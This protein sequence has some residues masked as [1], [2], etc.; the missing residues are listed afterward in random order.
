M[1]KFIVR[2]IQYKLLVFTCNKKFRGRALVLACIFPL[3]F[4]LNYDLI[5][6]QQSFSY[7][8]ADNLMPAFKTLVLMDS[9]FQIAII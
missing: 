2:L 9:D 1:N 8:N 7:P 3:I 4:C 5:L 6:L